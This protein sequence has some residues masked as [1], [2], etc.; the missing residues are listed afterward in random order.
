[1]ST[2]APPRFAYRPAL[3]GVRGLAVAAVLAFHG[4][5][6]A[7]P[8]GFLGVDA[9]F[10]LSGFLI[11]SLLLAEHRDTGR[12]DLVAFWGR[13]FRRLLPALLL[14]LAVVLLV[15]RW[16][17]PDTELTALRWDALAALGYV[18]NWR[19][20]NRD[21][22]YFA[23]TGS[24]SPLQHTWSLGIEEQFYLGWPLLL[25]LLLALAARRAGRAPGSGTRPAGRSAA[26]LA[27]TLGGALAS[28]V[29]A[30]LL[31]APDAVDRVYYGTDT[32]AVAL[33]IGAALAVALARRPATSHA[34]ATPATPEDATPEDAT[35]E[36]ATPAPAAAG[37]PS[38]RVRR[39]LGALALAGAVGTGWLW[40]TA[41]GGDPWLYRGGL[42]LAA[43]A[44]AAV[45]AHA[46]VSPGGPT[47]RLLALPPLVWTG[48]ISYGLYL[49]HWPLFQWC[50]AERTG[51]T[52][53][54]LLA[55]RC[56]LTLAVAVAS[57]LLV[58]RPIR[59]ARRLPR[60]AAALAGAAVAAVAALAVFGTVVPPV[61]STPPAAIAWDA[62][63]TP[64]ATAGPV[65]GSAAPTPPVRRPGREPGRLPR[66]TFLGDSVSWSLAS[67]LPEQ[68]RLA[69]S[70]RA[71]QGCGIA[72]LPELRYVG[73]DHT[74]YPGCD[75]WDNR[76]WKSVDADDPDVAV[77]LLDR[78]ELVDRRLDGRWQHVGD[79]AYDEYLAGELDRAIDIAGGRG[80]HVVLLTAPYTRRAERPDGGLWPE[81]DA[82][83]VDA[84]NRL[85][86]DAAVRKEASLL[87]LNRRVCPD[88]EFTWEAGGV[89]VRS[90]GLHFTPRGVREWIAP[91]LLPELHRLAVQG[92]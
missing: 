43:L 69:V 77:I 8:G 52:G 4:G 51:L 16:L 63:P 28:A 21:G 53:P 10:V 31:F 32:R 72:R 15:S 1:M 47:A 44:V 27:F 33:L 18:A 78:W 2:T 37:A 80:A 41:N 11:T 87:D 20:A 85:L 90:D 35:P 46:T 54:A 91:W 45:I 58:E 17:L 36:D 60:V 39:V 22:D 24:P 74:N 5:V 12:I 86:A 73:G 82:Q 9:F 6:A 65:A 57:Y 76:W 67:Y 75:T 30:A 50:D 71:V 26:V 40:A 49:W 7:L 13:R 55:A 61:P 83:R 84:W 68:D 64:D 89:R 19:M 38:P 70:V 81:D 59:R 29:A 66:V 25:G 92:A 48:R 79:P 62:T 23:A 34:P 88:G 3:D 14:V 42:T 56:A